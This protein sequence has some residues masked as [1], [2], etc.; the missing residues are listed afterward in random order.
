M[1]NTVKTKNGLFIALPIQNWIVMDSIGHYCTVRIDGKRTCNVF[2]YDPNQ[3]FK[4]DT[5]YVDNKIGLLM[6][7]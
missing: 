6:R 1:V 4:K 5:L 2:Q 3:S 7:N